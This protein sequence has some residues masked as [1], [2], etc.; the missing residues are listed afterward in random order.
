MTKNKHKDKIN[1]KVNDAGFY[2]GFNQFITLSSKLIIAIVV[3]WII[4]DPSN[5]GQLLNDAKNASLQ[6]FN[7]FYIYA[8][9]FYIVVCLF[10]AIYPRFGRIKLGDPDGVPEYSRFSWFSMMFGAGIG[11]GMLGYS[12]AEPVWHLA[13]NPDLIS[14]R[15]IVESALLSQNIAVPENADIFAIYNEHVQAGTITPIADLI[16]PKTTSALDSSY[17]YAFMHW[18]LATWATYAMVGITLAYFG[19]RRGY[20]LTIRSGLSAIFGNKL[21]GGLGNIIDIAAV[22]ATLLGISQTIGLGL[23]AFASGLHNITG[24][25]WLMTA[26]EN[27]EPTTGA[28]LVCLF[29]VMALSI[30]SAASGVGKGIKW[31]SNTN[32][33]LSFSLIAFFLIFGS[34]L[35][36]FELLGKSIVSYIIHLPVMTF[37]VWDLASEQG[38]WQTGWTVF[39]WAWAIAF[40]TFVGIFLARISKNRT[41]REFVAGAIIAPSLMCFIWFAFIGGTALDLELS[42]QAGGRIFNAN[43]TYQLYE[44]VNIMLSPGLAQVLSIM[45]VILLLTYLVT[46]ADSAIL[47]VNTICAGGNITSTMSKRHIV[48]WGVALGA[49]TAALLLAGG[50]KAI[51]AAMIIGTIPFAI[52]LILMGISLLIALSKEGTR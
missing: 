26:G 4:S 15:Q 27:P 1:I 2:Q 14:A 20:Q 16:I 36:A 3:I 24:A 34:T 40:G 10:V 50:L 37:T 6:Y 5:A 45:I 22:L 38:G 21:N 43:L 44:V 35:F 46:S 12:V 17:R 8:V 51:Q 9:G 48:I 32:M 13:T 49:M 31:L 18:G 30:L 7:A 39:Y 28:L 33:V 42:G 19:H 47:V 25:S 23:S 41:I 29:I 52:I 11:I